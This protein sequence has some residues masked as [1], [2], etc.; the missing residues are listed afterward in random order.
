MQGLGRRFRYQR[1]RREY[2]SHQRVPSSR[3]RRMKTGRTSSKNDG[4]SSSAA[5][6]IPPSLHSSQ[7]VS[8]RPLPCEAYFRE[9]KVES[10]DSRGSAWTW[11]LEYN[12]ADYLHVNETT[13]LDLE[14]AHRVERLLHLQA[15]VN[16]QGLNEIPYEELT[17]TPKRTT[18]R[19]VNRETRNG[20]PSPV[21][22]M[23][24]AVFTVSP[25]RQ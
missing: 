25:N 23:R 7:Y 19:R 20:L 24:L 4:R 6:A 15:D 18:S 11:I 13:M 16:P 1:S 3:R 22:S 21:D 14:T 2:G 12:S 10:K 17:D 5:R 8:I 9:I